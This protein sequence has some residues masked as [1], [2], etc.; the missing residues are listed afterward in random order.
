MSPSPEPDHSPQSAIGG[1]LLLTLALLS[2]LGPLA[3]DAYLP[4][5]TAMAEDLHTP[6]SSIQLTLTTFLF[7]LA[8]GQLVIGTLSDR[9]GRRRPLL[10]AMSMCTLAGI[11][12]TLAPSIELLIPLRF[13][14]GFT[15]AAGVV[16]A[17]SI[18]RD[19]TDGRAAVRTFSLLTA[20]GSFAPVVAPLLGGALMPL[21][22]WRGVLGTVALLTALMLLAAFL[23][24]PESLPVERRTGGGIGATFRLA[25]DLFAN[26]QYAGYLLTNAFTF[27]AL[28]AYISA[29]P[30]VFQNVF[31]LSSGTYSLAFTFNSVGLIIASATNARI[32]SRI[33]PATILFVA[34]IAM[35]LVILILGLT[36]LTGIATIVTVLPLTFLF[37]GTMG[38][39][40][41]NASA[42]ALTSISRAMGPRRRCWERSSSRSELLRHR[43]S[44]WEAKG[45][46]SRW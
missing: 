44:G 18:V 6:A 42:L 37:V 27:G 11:G 25:A 34:Q 26:R 30:F 28:F 41:G 23:A 9:F 40:I 45:P 22:D 10:I 12:C 24:A 14:Q 39:T 17:R 29:S 13:V 20:I 16:I 15:G 3:I 5:F 33:E 19:L 1:R 31:G 38:F 7:G 2:A 36:I 43:W 35:N 4:G 21:V 46:P 8:L 32:V